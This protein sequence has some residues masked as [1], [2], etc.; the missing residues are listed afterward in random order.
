MDKIAGAKVWFIPDA[1]YPTIS[2]GHF[3]SHEAICVLNPG[4]KDAEIDVVLY[5]EDRDKMSGFKVVCKAERTNHIRMDKLKDING[6]GVPKGVPYAMMV[7]SSENIIV[8]Y[9]R[10]DTT[11]AEMALMTTMAYPL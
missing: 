7:T 9:S 2:N 1:Y 11:Q 4:V 6:N 10:M 8:Q 5:F 3:P